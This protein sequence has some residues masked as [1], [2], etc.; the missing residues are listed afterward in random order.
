AGVSNGEHFSRKQTEGG[1]GED[2]KP[3][4]DASQS[5]YEDSTRPEPAPATES[6]QQTDSVRELFGEHEIARTPD[7][8]RQAAPVPPTLPAEPVAAGTDEQADTSAP[9]LHG[10]PGS[11][12]HSAGSDEI[13]LYA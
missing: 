9:D 12:R 4:P 3:V 13:E 2:E 1:K 11:P 8:A 10:T 6:A 5:Q 7:P